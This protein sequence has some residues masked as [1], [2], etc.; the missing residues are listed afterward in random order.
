MNR[1]LTMLMIAILSVGSIT[2]A[3]ARKNPPR[4]ERTV[5]GTY[6]GTWLPFGNR[7][8]ASTGGVGCM[9]VTA[10]AGESYL[11][12][13]VTDAHGQPVFVSVYEQV[14]DAD[15]DEV[16]PFYGS[17]CGTTTQPIRIRPGST[18]ELWV[19]YWDPW[20]P[21]CVPGMATVGTVSVTLS[22]RS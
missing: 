22:N 15:W 3:E 10:K 18:Y 8:C 5:E 2:V 11:T 7:V 4:H 1:I 19:G 12:A 20:I 21:S 14:S 6:N 16:P 17:F 9:T 13:K